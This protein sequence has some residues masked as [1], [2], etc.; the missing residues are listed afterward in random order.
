MTS[1][2]KEAEISATVIKAKEQEAIKYKDYYS[3]TEHLDK[4]VSHRM[5]AMRRGENEGFLKL[6]VRPEEDKAIEALTRLFVK[7]SSNTSEYVMM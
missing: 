6:T 3:F 5:L 1:F 2:K 4:C 7:S